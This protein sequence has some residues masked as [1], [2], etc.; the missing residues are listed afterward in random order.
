MTLFPV[1]HRY[2]SSSVIVTATRDRTCDTF[3]ETR[4]LYSKVIF[5]RLTTHGSLSSREISHPR[6]DVIPPPTPNEQQRR[7]ILKIATAGDDSGSNVVAPWRLVHLCFV[8]LEACQRS[9]VTRSRRHCKQHLAGVAVKRGE[10][11]R[12][13]MLRQTRARTHPC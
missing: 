6:A 1:L 9:I 5:Y 11:R 10:H 4:L 8:S 3:H 12:S 7:A 2:H 13:T